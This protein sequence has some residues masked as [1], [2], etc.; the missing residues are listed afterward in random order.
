MG[1]ARRAVFALLLLCSPGGGQSNQADSGPSIAWSRM[2]WHSATVGGRAIEHAALM[3]EVQLDSLTGPA[4]MQLDTG[5]NNDV[6]YTKVYEQLH[7]KDTPGD[8]YWIGLSG[9]AAGRP[10]KG[11]WFAHSRDFGDA[12]AGKTPVVGTIGA[13]FFERRILLLDF[14]GQ[15]LAILGKG[16]DLPPGLARQIDFVPLDYHNGKMF[17]A[18]TLNGSE[19]RDLFFDSGSSAMALMTS[20]RRWLE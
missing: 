17:V 5:A 15:R 13:A 9:T 1:T 8:Q 2:I 4:V 20:R 16:E 6:L 3:V 7:P 14:V 10:F 19:E 11:D 12:V 18:L